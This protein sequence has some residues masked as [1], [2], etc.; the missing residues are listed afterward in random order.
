MKN[1]TKTFVLTVIAVSILVLSV[2]CRKEQDVAG[3][4]AYSSLAEASLDTLTRYEKAVRAGDAETSAGIPAQFWSPPIL[5]LK[6]IKVYTH[7]VNLVVVQETSDSIEKGL[8]IYVPISSYIPI[9]GDDGFVFTSLGD[10]VFQFKRKVV[11]N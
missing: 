1:Q 6:P 7:R 2:A 11:K 8:Y 4:P 3:R 9:S 5:D 10:N